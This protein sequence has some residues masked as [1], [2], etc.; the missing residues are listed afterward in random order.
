MIEINA[1]QI[2]EFHPIDYLFHEH[3][4][5]SHFPE[6]FIPQKSVYHN[7]VS[8]NGTF[9]KT[10]LPRMEQLQELGKLSN[11]I[12]QY[13]FINMKTIVERSTL[14]KIVIYL[15]FWKIKSKHYSQA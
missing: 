4:S 13:T 12:F 14:Q 8:Q 3:F 6:C 7:S 15:I 1:C 5:T 11:I 2:P 10:Q 9:S